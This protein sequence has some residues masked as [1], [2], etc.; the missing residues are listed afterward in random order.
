MNDSLTLAEAIPLAVLCLTG[1]PSLA[2]I[3][4]VMLT[5][6]WPWRRK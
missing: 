5:G 3:W 4:G 6:T 2:V 1:P